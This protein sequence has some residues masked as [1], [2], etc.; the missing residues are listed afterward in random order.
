[1][2]KQQPGSHAPFVSA[3]GRAGAATSRTRGADPGGK[4]VLRWALAHCR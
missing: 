1:M 3:C 4:P 2:N